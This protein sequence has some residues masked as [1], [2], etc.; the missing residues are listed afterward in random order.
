VLVV[1]SYLP[2]LF[3]LCDRL[4]VMRRGRLSA[5]RPIG[6][7]TPETVLAAAVGETEQPSTRAERGIPM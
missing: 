4:A 1:S 3:G 7:W 2:E 6:E 5:A